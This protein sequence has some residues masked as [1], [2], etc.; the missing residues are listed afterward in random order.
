MVEFGKDSFQKF[1]VA[2]S[3]YR[4][5]P[6]EHFKISVIVEVRGH[7]PHE[8]TVTDCASG[9]GWTITTGIKSLRQAIAMQLNVLSLSNNCRTAFTSSF[10]ETIV[11]R[12][13]PVARPKLESGRSPS[14]YCFTTFCTARSVITLPNALHRRSWIATLV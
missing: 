3:I 10:L 12:P 11:G 5:T 14:L 4:L 9:N 2:F 6:T 13:D 1:D 7:E 8:L